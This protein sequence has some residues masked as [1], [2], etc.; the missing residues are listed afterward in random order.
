[1]FVLFRKSSQAG[2]WKWKVRDGIDPPHLQR[3]QQHTS[4]GCQGK[5]RTWPKPFWRQ[6][7]HV[8]QGLSRINIVTKKRHIDHTKTSE[9]SIA[10]GLCISPLMLRSVSATPLSL[11]LS[12]I[13]IIG[14]ECCKDFRNSCGAKEKIPLKRQRPNKAE[15]R[16]EPDT[17]YSVHKSV[18]S[19]I[20]PWILMF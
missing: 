14:H 11:S 8:A 7:R 6:F 12:R 13:S 3:M 5:G 16:V 20:R 17:K 1:M 10:M 18:W 4:E 9:V 19:Q 15:T 2:R